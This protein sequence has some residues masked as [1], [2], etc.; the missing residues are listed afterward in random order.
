MT[1]FVAPTIARD[2]D[3][4]TGGV[5]CY[6]RRHASFI[7]IGAVER[8]TL[9]AARVWL[10][11]GGE[12]LALEQNESVVGHRSLLVTHFPGRALAGA[13]R[14][15]ARLKDRETGGSVVAFAIH[16]HA[17]PH[18]IA[19]KGR[20]SALIVRIGAVERP[21]ANPGIVRFALVVGFAD[22]FEQ[23]ITYAVIRADLA[24]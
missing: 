22:A 8:R 21:A 6:G 23:E 20:R 10:A 11:L 3:A 13:V 1:L 19:T 5:A 14:N 17:V 7:R 9:Q 24:A 15:S 4:V 12:T 18:R 2:H 16:D